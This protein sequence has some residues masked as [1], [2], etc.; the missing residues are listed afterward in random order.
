MPSINLTVLR[1]G[2]DRQRTKGGARPDSLYD[3]V[4]GQL[5]D[6]GT[7]KN[8]PGT[9]RRATLDS[10]TRGLMSFNGELHTFSHDIVAVPAGYVLHVLS[11]PDSLPGD[12][13]TLSK[14]HFASPFLGYPYVVAEFSDGAVYHYWLR[15]SG[16]WAAN[17][18]YSTG[19]VVEPT[20][21]NGIGYQATRI[22]APYPSWAP[23]VPRAIGDFV[24]PTVYNDF[25]FEAVDTIGA[26]PR[27]GSVEPNW[28]VNAGEQVIED[29]NGLTDSTATT[30]APPTASIPT[31]VAERY[32]NNGA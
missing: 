25:Y 32:G 1:G 28:P 3:L 6:A 29:V 19:D 12:V 22:G 26:T 17:T 8:R 16:S 23:N 27:S 31:A 5:T 21:A 15:S 24:E 7:V 10:T 18:P 11:H 14:I 30:T 13:K 4:N 20:V 9:I 2:I